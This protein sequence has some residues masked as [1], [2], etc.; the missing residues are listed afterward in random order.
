MNAPAISARGLTRRFGKL[1]AVD[2]V[3]LDIP[4]AEIYGF[5]GP[6]GSGK[7]TTIRM[8]C[9]LVDPSEGSVHVLD[10]EMPRDAELLRH[11]LGYMTQRFSLWEDLTVRENLEFMAR[12]FGLQGSQ[13]RERIAK[14]VEE[15]D[16]GRMLDQRSGT[17]S[18]GQRQR[19]GLAAATLHEPELLLLDEPT[20]AVDPQNRRD[21]WESLFRLVDRGT[22]ILVSTHYMDE[23]ER[24]HRIAILD[25]GK[26]VAQGSPKQLMNDLEDTVLEVESDNLT[27][28]RNTL[29]RFEHL[30]SVAQLG[31]RLHLLVAREL[32]DAEAVVQRMLRDAGVE[33][34]V[35]R[36][37]P[38]LE[39]VF[40]VATRERRE[41]R[42]QGERPS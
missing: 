14:R 23:A 25:R 33:A 4:R 7:S 20:S 41:A 38:S 36:T 28:V 5:L 32:A 39:D 26:L 35:T 18:G 29:A 27:G 6:N 11:K 31:A 12:V 34:R 42:R 21:F 40:V 8:M 30:R 24:C 13:R 2:H 1:V 16:L 17:M 9:G 15:Y 37:T 19:L 10:H 3:D 22:T